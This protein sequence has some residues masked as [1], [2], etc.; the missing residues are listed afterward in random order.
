MNSIQ[1]DFSLIAPA[2]VAGLLVLAT[3]VPLGAQVLKRGIVFI[4]LA[5]LWALLFAWVGTFIARGIDVS[6]ELQSLAAFI[7]GRADE[8]GLVVLSFDG[9]VVAKPESFRLHLVPEEGGDGAIGILAGQ[10]GDDRP[11][12]GIALG[13]MSQRQWH[14]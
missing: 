2:F 4:D 7:V 11:M 9:P 14:R 8:S 13:G 3:H 5:T 10:P 12:E 1:L 6:G